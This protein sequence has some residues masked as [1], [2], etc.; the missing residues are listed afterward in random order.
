M[1]ETQ[2]GDESYLENRDSELV[3]VWIDMVFRRA[4]FSKAKMIFL[5]TV[6]FSEHSLA[7]WAIY[8]DLSKTDLVFSKRNREQVLPRGVFIKNM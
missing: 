6:T 4:S 1:Q 3:S 7:S 2:S 5:E 8:T